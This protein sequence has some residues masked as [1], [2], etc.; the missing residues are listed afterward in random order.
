[1][2]VP[3][4][5][6]A[7]AAVVVATACTPLGGASRPVVMKLSTNGVL[8][9]AQGAPGTAVTIQGRDLGGPSNSSVTFGADDLARG[10]VVAT[11]SDIVSWTPSE[12]VVKVPAGTRPGGGYLFVTV[13]GVR[14]NTLSFSIGQ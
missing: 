12:I 1:M 14:S 3:L 2:K 4:F 9:P 13:L 7:L 10:G 8:G 6:L 11:S 5:A